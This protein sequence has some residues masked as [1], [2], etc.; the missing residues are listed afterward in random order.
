MASQVIATVGLR[1]K[2]YPACRQSA[3]MRSEF[4]GAASCAVAI[5]LCELES[6]ISTGM[7]PFI[8]CYGTGFFF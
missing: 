4:N 2:F 1:H 5:G 7:P 6:M 3:L 8:P